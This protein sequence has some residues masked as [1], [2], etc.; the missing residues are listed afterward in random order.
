MAVSQL[1]GG[2][3]SERQTELR[4][5]GEFRHEQAERPAWQRKLLPLMAA[6]LILAAIFFAVMSVFELREFYDEVA[7]EPLD[8]A[9][10]F[11]EME[12]GAPADTLNHPDY[13]RFRVLALLEAEALQ[14]RYHQANATML[15]RIWT[16]QIGFITGMLLA[17]VGAAF[18]LGRLQEAPT[19]FELA[20]DQLKGALATSSPGIVLA[21]LGTGLMALTIWIPFG[22]ETRDINTYLEAPPQITAPAPAN[23]MPT[24]IPGAGQRTTPDAEELRLFGTP[25]TAPSDNSRSGATSVGSTPTPP[26]E[27]GVE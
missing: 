9:M 8:L 18:I 1:D 17:L 10:H 4:S 5:A 22:V 6:V 27:G 16:R 20:S 3:E 24:E 23:V 12:Q 19:T 13:V 15:G 2:N 7:H 26:S 14:R 25:G 21:V 11:T